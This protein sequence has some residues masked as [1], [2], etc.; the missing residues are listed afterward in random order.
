MIQNEVEDPGLAEEIQKVYSE[1]NHGT[2]KAPTSRRGVLEQFGPPHKIGALGAGR[3]A[4]GYEYRHVVERQVGIAVPGYSILKIGAGKTGAERLVFI[5]EFSEAD[6][7][8][9]A[10][11]A[12]WNEDVGFGFNLQ[13]F[14]SV[15]P[16]SDTKGLLEKWSTESWATDLLHTPVGLVDLSHDPDAGDHG[17]RFSGM[18]KPDVQWPAKHT[19]RR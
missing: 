7:V 13:L 10:G 16:T 14:F 17:M 3:Y 11:S 12:T 15:A 9:A 6:E 5:I 19:G 8:L 2:L 4:F 18:P 1:E